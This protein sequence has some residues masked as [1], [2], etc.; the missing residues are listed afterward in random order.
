MDSQCRH[1]KGTEAEKESDGHYDGQGDKVNL[2]SFVCD[3][4]GGG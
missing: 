1:G 4:I 2:E 3:S